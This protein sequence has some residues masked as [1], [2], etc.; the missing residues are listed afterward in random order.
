MA[1]IRQRLQAQDALTEANA[2]TGWARFAN[3][4]PDTRSTVAF[5]VGLFG[6]L[7]FS[8]GRLRFAK[9][10]L[11][12][13]VF[14]VWGGWAGYQT[15]WPFLIGCGLKVATTRYGGAEA[16]RKIK[17][18]MFGLIAGDM[19]SGIGITIFGICYNLI[20][21]ELPKPYLVLLG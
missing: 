6:V 10:P 1:R 18:L 11:H 15:A 2:T 8:A 12:P 7:L 19:L 20:T 4:T 14:L 17:P 16:Y 3:P 21:G 5:L 13:V 9:W